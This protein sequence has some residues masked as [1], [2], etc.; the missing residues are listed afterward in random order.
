[1]NNFT[2]LKKIVLPNLTGFQDDLLVYDKK[3]LKNYNGKFLYA[4]RNNGT[5]LLLL[6]NIKDFDY[7]K[8]IDELQNILNKIF[9]YFKGD[10]KN[11]LCCDGKTIVSIDW[12]K[13]HTILKGFANNVYNRKKYIDSLNINSIAFDLVHLIA[14]KKLWKKMISEDETS[15]TLRGLR[16]GFDWNRI[17][18]SNNFEDMKKQLLQLVL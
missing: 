13:L 10:N 12:E 18:K 1:M 8:S 2:Q 6:D 15:A 16:A 3:A 11:F 4:Y 14:T 9:T 5:N 17:K 7:T